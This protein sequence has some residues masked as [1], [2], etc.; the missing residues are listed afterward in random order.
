MKLSQN[1]IAHWT[2]D[3][4]RSDFFINKKEKYMGYI[5]RHSDDRFEVV[6][7]TIFDSELDGGPYD[8]RDHRKIVNINFDPYVGIY[9]SYSGLIQSKC[10][11]GQMDDVFY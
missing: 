11:V 7:R 10:N 9:D 2:F 1:F 4:D 3:R 8:A 6:I 5:Y